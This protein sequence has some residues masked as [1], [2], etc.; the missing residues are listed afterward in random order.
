MGGGLESRCVGRVCGADGAVR[1]HYLVASSWHFTLFHMKLVSGLFL[2][3]LMECNM[4]VYIEATEG[5]DNS[6]LVNN[7]VF[8]GLIII[9]ILL[10]NRFMNN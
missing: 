2:F 8:A 9:I 7:R 4:Q 6:D 1:R 5:R 10:Q 3:I